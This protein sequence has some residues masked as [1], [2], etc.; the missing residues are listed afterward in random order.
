MAT[1]RVTGPDGHTYE[2]T[3]PDGASDAEVLAQVQQHVAQPQPKVDP[4][5]ATAQQ[6]SGL[7][8]FLAGVGGAI[9]GLYVG[10]KQALGMA[11]PQEVDE[12]KQAMAGLA[13]TGMGKTGEIVGGI[14]PTIPLMMIPGVNSV[15]G[16]AGLGA[17]QGALQPTSG[18]ESRLTNTLVGAAL[19]GV[20]QK[21][22]DILGGALSSRAA[23]NAASLDAQRTANAVRDATLRD[24]QSAGYVLPPSQVNPSLANR[25]LE[26]FAG[27]LTTA[28]SA[29]QKNQSV[30]NSL[31]KAD[32]GI[33]AE[34]P[35]TLDAIKAARTDAAQAYAPIRS[36]GQINA[37]EGYA[38]ALNDI[39]T[40]YDKSHGGMKTLRNPAVEQTLRDA[41]QFNMDSDSALNL[42]GSLRENGYA[43]AGPLSNAADKRL[44]KTQLGVANA[45][46]DLI[47]RNLTNAGQGDAV[48]AFRA[49]RQKIA[50]TYDAESAFNPATG[51]IQSAKLAQMAKK[52][53]PFTGGL[54]T[55]A[56]AARAFPK[57]TQ[58][59]TSSMPGI[60]PLDYMG[61]VLAGSAFNPM[62][63]AAPFARPAVRAGILSAPFQKAMVQPPSYEAGL[64]TKLLA[65]NPQ[66]TRELLGLLG[67]AE[68]PRLPQ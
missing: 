31:V 3:G 58:E 52:G 4:F 30:T 18:D 65:S 63:F 43:N 14:A 45:I 16:A 23:A 19:G 11:S 39:A 25:F 27:K 44:G 8:N 61:G 40:A 68:A 67:G 24:A 33:P 47:D 2:V 46:E 29:A 15:A 50:K 49:A 22:G 57:A 34:T 48:T 55:A 36:F 5:V 37:D 54:Q 60:S 66:K 56:E 9:H 62:A 59:I 53:A 38:N 10:G 42:I 12:Q 17:V 28:Q 6:D 26:G 32:L 51:N 20:G 13:S 1:Y 64:L 41:S 35:L 7:D 21:A